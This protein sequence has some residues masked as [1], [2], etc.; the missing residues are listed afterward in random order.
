M[1][2][3]QPSLNFA[4]CVPDGEAQVEVMNSLCHEDPDTTLKKMEAAIAAALKI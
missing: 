3:C 4:F 2:T 1:T